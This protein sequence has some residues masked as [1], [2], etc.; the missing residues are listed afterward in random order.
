MKFLVAALSIELPTIRFLLLVLLS[1]VVKKVLFGFVNAKYLLS[2]Y[3]CKLSLI[4]F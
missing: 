1:A 2:A 3:A 4:Y